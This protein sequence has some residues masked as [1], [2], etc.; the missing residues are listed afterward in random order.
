MSDPI[1][2]EAIADV[3]TRLPSLTTAPCVDE[4]EIEVA[5][6]GNGDPAA[7]VTVFLDD[8]VSG[9]PYPWTRL[10]PIH[11]LIW[12]VFVDRGVPQKP[13]V[14]FRLKSEKHEPD[15]EEGEAGN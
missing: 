2:D 10:K 4:I 12:Q 7:F 3:N 1:V 15:E 9:N 14:D 6:D 5:T 13:Y 11:D 8:D